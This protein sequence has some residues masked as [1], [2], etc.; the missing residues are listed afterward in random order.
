MFIDSDIQ[1]HAGDV[2]TLLE[3]DKDIVCGFYPKK[4]INWKAVTEAVKA[5]Y[6]DENPQILARFSADMVYTPALNDESRELR[7]IY[8]LVEL[9]EGG[10]G[11][12]LIK[13]EVF[14]RL[15]DLHPE[16]VYRKTGPESDTIA[17]LFDAKIDPDESPY[18]RFLSED[19]AFCSL[20]R[21][22]GYKI[23]LAPWIKLA[24]HGYYQ[25]VGDV[26]AIGALHV[27][28]RDVA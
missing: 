3:Q 15:I 16:L 20:A 2:F 11:F 6:A 12:C 10:T 13:R 19:Y 4:C 14:C 25:Y 7:T 28:M 9:H 8:D 5:G 18:K 27:H 21:S 22:E 17:C 23:W 26:E 1:F 24:H